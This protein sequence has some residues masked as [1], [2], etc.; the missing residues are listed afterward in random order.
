MNKLILSLT[1][2][3]LA[4]CTAPTTPEDFKAAEEACESFGGLKYFNANSK[5]ATCH[6]MYAVDLMPIF[7]AK[8]AAEFQEAWD[9]REKFCTNQCTVHGG[10]RQN[11]MTLSKAYCADGSIVVP[12]TGH[13]TTEEFNI[14]AAI[15]KTRAECDL[16]YPKNVTA[17]PNN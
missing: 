9:E 13:L 17:G 10:P 11:S 15:E 3:A 12:E 14:N 2:L 16:K 8:K 4:G 5:V 6:N 1:I 7:K